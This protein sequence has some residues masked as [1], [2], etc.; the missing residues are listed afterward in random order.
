MK[1]DLILGDCIDEIPKLEKKVNLIFTS[2]PYYNAKEYSHWK[3]YQDY[4]CFLNNF[5][6]QA[7]LCLV[8][9]GFLIINTSPVIEARLNRQHQSKRYPIPFDI[10][11]LISKLGFD[12]ID[13]II[14]EKPEYSVPNRNGG[15]FNNRR[16]LAYKPNIVTEYIMVYR[17]HTEK[18]ID[19][20][21]RKHDRGVIENSL[22]KDGYERTNIWKINPNS[23]SNHPAVFPNE[24]ASKIIKYYSY[25]DDV[26][27]D[28][29][30]GSGT[31]GIECMKL[32]RNFYGIEKNPEYFNYAKSKIEDILAIHNQ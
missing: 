8:E 6:I 21:I 14:W 20:N 10:H 31:V 5:L 23:N 25:V 15:F 1:Y 22:V 24:L 16:P 30:M 29:F 12:F 3:T 27:L 7:K 2:P 13:D 4:L 19:F 18:L 32:N 9:G 17:K 11:N 28:P 26:I